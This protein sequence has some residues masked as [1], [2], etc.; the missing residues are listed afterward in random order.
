MRLVLIVGALCC[1]VAL[2]EPAIAQTKADTAAATAGTE[3]DKAQTPEASAPPQSV[4]S[5]DII[6][7]ASRRSENIRKVA[8]AISAYNGAKLNEAQITSLTDLTAVTPSIQISNTGTNFNINIRGVGNGNLNQAGGEPGVAVQFDGVYL[9][10]PALAVTTFLDVARVEI[11]RGPQG[12][13]SGRNAT[14]GAINILPNTPTKNLTYG[15]DLSVGGGPATVR[16]SGYVSGPLNDDGTL[17]G[18]LAVEQNYNQGYTRNLAPVGPSRLDGI[19]DGA[20]RGQLEWRPT[21]RFGVR[22][23]VEYQK[24][25]DTGSAAYLLGTPANA[26][27]PIFLQGF[28]VG[29]PQTREAYANVG[30]KQLEAETVNLT[31]DWTVGTGQL[32]ALGSYNHSN[33][34]YI[35]DGDGSL[36]NFTNSLYINNSNQKYAELIY[37]SDATKRFNYILGGNYYEEQFRQNIQVPA[38]FLPFTFSEGGTINTRSFAFFAHAQYTFLPSAKIFAGVRYTNDRKADNEFNNF[39]GAISQQASWDRVTYE[40]GLSYDFTPLISGYVK[41]A[42]GYKS[43][44]FS[45]GNIAPAYNP[46]TSANYE[47]GLKGRFFGGVLQAN[48]AAFHTNYNNLQV[49]QIVGFSAAITNAAQAKI[50]GVEVEAVVRP[51]PNF[52]IEASGSYLNARFDQF[53]TVDSSRPLLGALDLANNQLPNAPHVTASAGAYYD[54]QTSRGRLSPGVRFDWK[55]TLYFSEFNIP[56]S[57]QNSVGKLNLYLNYESADRRWIAGLYALNVTGRQIRSNVLVVS[58][59]LGSLALAQYQPDRQVGASIGY[60]F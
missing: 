30:A 10:Q 56:I 36:A 40:A 31:V 17:L 6:V 25:E 47:A 49:N 48:I 16:S 8:A 60:H 32:K 26:P 54:I 12:T 42:T 7:T 44:G 57:S 28:P 35:Q 14:G 18:R 5:P 55:S 34:N 43:G 22:L 3:P 58:A 13:L 51:V 2:H 19:N 27:L 37:T 52:R 29:N 46:E 24:E 41:Y 39:V 15:A 23:L 4:A 38:A 9:G 45:A 1:E 21:S 11:L 53:T 59:L 20:A 33:Q 50:D